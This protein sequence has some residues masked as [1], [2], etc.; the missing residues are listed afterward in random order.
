MLGEWNAIEADFQQTYG[1]DLS[2]PAVR[3]RRSWRWFK[4]RLAGLLQ[5]ES[6]IQVIF[7]P[8]PEQRKARQE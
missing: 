7:N 1:I 8:T 3:H 5:V 6:R 2:D 4:V